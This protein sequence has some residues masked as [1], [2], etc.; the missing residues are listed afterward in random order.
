MRQDCPNVHYADCAIHNPALKGLDYSKDNVFDALGRP[1]L[2]PPESEFMRQLKIFLGTD[3]KNP[4]SIAQFVDVMALL[5]GEIEKQQSKISYSDSNL[6]LRLVSDWESCIE[7]S[8]KSADEIT[9]ADF[10]RFLSDKY[11]G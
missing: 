4:A 2:K 8:A 11:L 3:D 6:L 1:D 7:K 10:M 5:E 9:F